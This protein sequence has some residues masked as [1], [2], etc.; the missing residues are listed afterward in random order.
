MKKNC[1]QIVIDYLIANNYD[2]LYNSY[3]DCGCELDDL[4]PCGEC[5]DQCVPA[6][7]HKCN[8]TVENHRFH[9]SPY[10]DDKANNEFGLF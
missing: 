2:G 10:K 4:I 8:C 3:L 9:M 7:R 6:Y 1:K 5:F